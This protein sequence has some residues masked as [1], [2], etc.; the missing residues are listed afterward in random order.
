MADLHHER[1]RAMALFDSLQTLTSRRSMFE[2]LVGDLHQ[3]ARVREGDVSRLARSWP[4]RG[5][6]ARAG[7]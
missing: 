4:P 3:E 5:T 1:N 6:R 2:E 7:C